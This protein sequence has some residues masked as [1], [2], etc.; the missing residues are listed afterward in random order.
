MKFREIQK[1][2]SLSMGYSIVTICNKHRQVLQSV[3]ND[4]RILEGILDVDALDWSEYPNR[5]TYCVVLD[6][7]YIDL[8]KRRIRE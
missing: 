1:R 8:L 7:E 6:C 4:V 2:Y 5:G 3:F